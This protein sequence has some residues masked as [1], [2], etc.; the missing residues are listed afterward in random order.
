MTALKT[1]LLGIAFVDALIVAIATMGASHA[2][3]A[4]CASRQ[5]P[6]G[7]YTVACWS[8]LPVLGYAAVG[9]VRDN[10]VAHTAVAGAYVVLLGIGWVLLFSTQSQ[11]GQHAQLAIPESAQAVWLAGV[12]A[13]QVVL[14][15]LLS[16]FIRW[17]SRRMKNR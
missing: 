7:Q 11:A 15:L 2:I 5:M 8:V 6:S 3:A 16:G 14:G 17:T 1:R 4:F 12:T 9:S 10:P 13:S